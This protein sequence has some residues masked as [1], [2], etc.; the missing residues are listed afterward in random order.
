MRL[1]YDNGVDVVRPAV[2]THKRTPTKYLAIAVTLIA[3]LMIATTLG[4]VFHYHA[5]SSE[6]NCPI[7]HLNHQP[8]VVALANDR[9]PALAPVGSGP[10]PKDN[11][12]VPNRVT[13]RVPARAPPAA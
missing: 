8:V 7:C 4:S 12:I 3:L 6:N 5:N 9:A 11:G 1:L 2:M 10:E 13:S